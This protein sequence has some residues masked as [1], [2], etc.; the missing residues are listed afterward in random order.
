MGASVPAY[1]RQ[2]EA[3]ASLS[4]RRPAEARV[5]YAELEDED[6][7]AVLATAVAGVPKALTRSKSARGTWVSP[8]RG[9][10]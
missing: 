5:A 2:A 6:L 1:V 10:K 3:D 9:F 8:D 7:S 4:L